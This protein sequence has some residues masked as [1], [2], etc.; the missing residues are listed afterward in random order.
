MSTVGNEE[1]SSLSGV[2]EWLP[3]VVGANV[4]R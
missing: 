2:D 4:G 1:C 3:E